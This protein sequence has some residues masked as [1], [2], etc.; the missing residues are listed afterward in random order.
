LETPRLSNNW[1][2][3]WLCVSRLTP[4]PYLRKGCGGVSWLVQAQAAVSTS[5][6]TATQSSAWPWYDDGK[7]R[8][9]DKLCLS[10]TR[11][12]KT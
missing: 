12:G 6:T 9:D 7:S 10:P 11:D 1:Y 5:R 4:P 3:K 8:I 2:E